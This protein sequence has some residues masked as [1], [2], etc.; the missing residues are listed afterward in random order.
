MHHRDSHTSLPFSAQ[1]IP[2]VTAV[3]HD[4]VTIGAYVYACGL[5]LHPTWFPGVIPWHPSE[6]AVWPRTLWPWTVAHVASGLQLAEG[7]IYPS[8]EALLH[9]LVDTGRDW[10]TPDTGLSPDI[11]DLIWFYRQ[12]S[13]RPWEETTC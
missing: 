8:A 7:L 5:A 12:I 4:P 9:A 1:L 11:Q 6:L 10:T 3:G 2:I 13:P